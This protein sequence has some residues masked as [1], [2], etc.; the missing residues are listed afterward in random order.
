MIS[1]TASTGMAASNI[2]G[3]ASYYKYVVALLTQVLGM[4]LH[5]WGAIAPT[6][7]SIEKLISYIRT[8][9]PALQRWKTTKVLIV[10]EG[11]YALC[12]IFRP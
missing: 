2:G 7:E 10:D 8:A 3:D 6:V 5:S 12:I 1:V 4:T 11:I 9:R